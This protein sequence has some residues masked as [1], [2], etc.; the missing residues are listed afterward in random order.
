MN[1]SQLLSHWRADPSIA[2][3]IT[4]WKTLPER[5]PDFKPLPASLHPSLIEILE[6]KGINRLYSHQRKAWDL[7]QS[8]QNVALVTGTASG[9]SLAYQ[10]P[11][12]DTLLKDE[13]SRALYLF[14]TKALAHDQLNALKASVPLQA[15]SYDG[16]TPQHHR[17]TI[18][19]QARLIVSNPDMLHL[20]ILPHHTSWKVFFSHLNYVVID[21]MHSYRGVFGSHV[22]NVIRRLKRV[23]EHYGS[24]PLFMLTSATIGNPQ[25]LAQALVEEPVTIIDED[26]SARGKKHFLVYNPPVIDEELGLR[27]G[28]Q[29]ESVRL[30]SELISYQVQTILFG[31]S[32]K[33]VEFMLSKLRENT[34]VPP[35][36]L[37]AY[38]S[39]Y[40]PEHRRQIEEDLRQSK[41]LVV[42]STNALE[43]G[44]DIGGMDAS[45][46]A[47]YP[48]TISGTWQ[49]AG[50]SG[51]TEKPSLSILVSSSAPLDQFLAHHPEYLFSTPPEHA[52]LDANNLL[53]LLKQ[54][55]CAAFEL[56]FKEGER[57]GNLSHS[58]T[59]EF[60][61]ILEQQNVLHASGD[62]YYWMSEGYPASHISLRSAGSDQLTLTHIQPSGTR[63]TIG[64][65]D[66]ESAMWMVHPGAIY[67]HGGTPFKV[68]KLNLEDQ[69]VELVDTAGDYYTEPEKR[70]EVNCLESL[71]H[72]DVRGGT[73]NYGELSVTSQ[74]IGYKKIN[75]EQYRV[76]SRESLDLPP[77]TLETTGYWLTLGEQTVN[78][79]KDSG[80]WN[81]G[82]PNYGSRWGEVREQVL[83][84]DQNRCQVCGA[85]WD[86]TQLHIHHK[87]PLRTFHTPQ[88]AHYPENLITLCPR[89]H[90]RVEAVVRVKHGLRGLSTLLHNLAPLLLMCDMRDLGAHADAESALGKGQPTIAIY[91]QIPAGIGF[92]KRLYERHYELLGQAYDLVSSC[93]CQ[94][95][96]P[97]CVGPG[98]ELG[99]GGKDETLAILKELMAT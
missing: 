84:R 19:K 49:Q 5:I 57:Y 33:S 95:G 35:S 18:R 98:G 2:S 80:S 93:V 63:Q 83:E 56:P 86:Q 81:S 40:L 31:R 10:L 64:T 15:A 34:D 7:V 39:G 44:I 71:G 26:R 50:R 4:T 16:D 65:I 52:L 92:S 48:G 53:I 43:L 74:V 66:R 46:L 11:S 85:R 54:I 55:Q 1:L 14:P 87:Q 30:L 70:T 90:R 88:E 37:R 42:V 79:L 9:K 58:Q 73:K 96:C 23:C 28:M 75:W 61:H 78:R 99:S 3:N 51:R 89:C 36:A 8:G 24:S 67:L 77:A 60:L 82:P 29:R 32:R 22:A 76:L 13:H 59:L 97:S 47:G 27:A 38:R 72:L 45:V 91:E 21:E 20:G 12:L 41:A 62:T 17:Q 94:D 69:N 25:E 6:T 68:K